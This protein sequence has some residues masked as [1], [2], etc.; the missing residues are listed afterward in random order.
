LAAMLTRLLRSGAHLGVAAAACGVPPARVR[1]WVAEGLT[2]GQRRVAGER[3]FTRDE[4]L[5]ERFATQAS[6]ALALHEM[7]LLRAADN[8]IKTRDVEEV[9]VTRGANGRVVKQTA[10]TTTL[11]PDARMLRWRLE[12]RFP[13]RWGPQVREGE[14]LG[15]AGAGQDV[16]ERLVSE[17]DRMHEAMVQGTALSVPLSF[18]EKDQHIEEAEVVDA[19]AGPTG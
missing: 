14:S 17:L 6:E 7:E 10:R 4:R 11:E 18:T 12:R 13:D 8:L 5:V 16:V 19:D 2:I 15:A 9:T 3:D 1:G